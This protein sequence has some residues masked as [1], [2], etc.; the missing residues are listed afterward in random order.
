MG[1]PH[2]V[3]VDP[4]TICNCVFFIASV[5]SNL[6][7]LENKIKNPDGKISFSKTKIFGHILK[8]IL[9]IKKIRINSSKKKQIQLKK[10]HRL[11]IR[12]KHKNAFPINKGK[13]EKNLFLKYT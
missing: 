2:G 10:K 7:F 3:K 5:F 12:H 9:L 4:F 11:F 1:V 6:I 8:K 13:D